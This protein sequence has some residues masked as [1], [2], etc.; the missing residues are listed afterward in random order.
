MYILAEANLYRFHKMRNHKAWE[1][2]RIRLD[3]SEYKGGFVIAE[4]PH[5]M[6][7]KFFDGSNIEWQRIDRRAAKRIIA[8]ARML[9]NM[10][11]TKLEN[12]ELKRRA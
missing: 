7:K 8:A 1:I 2:N 11:E 12:D 10:P 5:E 3:G 6:V 9:A 4:N